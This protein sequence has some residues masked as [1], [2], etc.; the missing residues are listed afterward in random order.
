MHKASY[1]VRMKKDEE[2][3]EEEKEQ[4]NDIMRNNV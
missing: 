2:E 1:D 3:K 4:Q